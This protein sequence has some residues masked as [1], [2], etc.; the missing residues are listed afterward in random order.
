LSG[1]SPSGDLTWW[2]SPHPGWEPG[3]D[4]PAEVPVVRLETDDEIVLIDPFLPPDDSFDPQRK[5]ARVLLTQPSHYR[6]T[7]DF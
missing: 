6:G 7:A 4:W 2:F 3:E 1:D 5:P